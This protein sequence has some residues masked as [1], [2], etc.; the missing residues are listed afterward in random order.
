M[1]AKVAIL[2]APQPGDIV[3]VSYDPKN[4]NTE[5]QIEGD[6]RYD[7]RIIRDNNKQQRA[8]ETQA[9][10]SGAPAPAVFG[11]VQHVLDDE[12]EWIVPEVCPECGARVDQ[13]TASVADHPTCEFCHKPLPCK[14]VREDY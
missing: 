6:P 5:I 8:A 4:H 9:L 10:L 12:P 7:P 3:K 14:R 2:H 13:S 11:V 1:T